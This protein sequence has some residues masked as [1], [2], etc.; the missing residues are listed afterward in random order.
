MKNPYY[1]VEN[2]VDRGLKEKRE[3]EKIK[4][5][6]ETIKAI[7]EE[8]IKDGLTE[9]QIF[10]LRYYGLDDQEISKRDFNIANVTSIKYMRSN[11]SEDQLETNR[12]NELID[13]LSTIE[14]FD[15]EKISEFNDRFHSEIKDWY[16]YTRDFEKDPLIVKKMR[17]LQMLNRM[18]HE[19]EFLFKSIFSRKN[20]EIYEEYTENYI[21]KLEINIRRMFSKIKSESERATKQLVKEF[22]KEKVDE[23]KN[24]EIIKY[25]IEA[26]KWMFSEKSKYIQEVLH[27]LQNSDEEYNYGIDVNDGNALIFDVPG[28]GQFSV[29]MGI[30]G[31]EKIKRLRE[32]EGVKDY[33]GEYLGNVYLLSKAD[34]ELLKN[35]NYEKLSDLDKQRYRIATQKIKEKEGINID[36]LIENAKDKEKAIEIINILKES[37]IKPEEVVTK[38]L[39]D[40]GQPDAIRD[41]I[42]IIEDNDYGIGLD[43]LPKC[44]TL[45]SVSQNKAIDIMEILDKIEEL[46]IDPNII[47]EYPNF[48]TVSKSEKIKPI[49]EVLEQYKINLTNHNLA[50][51]FQG[52]PENIKRN[53]DLAIEN[54]LYDLAQNGANKLFTCSNKTLNMRMNLFKKK[55]IPLVNVR[56]GKRR[57][58]SK[59][60]KTEEDI[61]EMYGI[62]KKQI[63]DELSQIEGQNLIKDNKYYVEE[64]NEQT[65]LSD[66]QQEISNSIYEK[67]DSYQED[68][69]VIR[70]GNYFY[71]A[72]KVKEQIDE[73]IANSNIQDIEKENINEILK[74]A[75]FKN[76]NINQ[77]EV[78]E[79]SEQIEGLVKEDTTQEK[80]VN[81]SD[82]QVT[83]Q[84]KE[85][86]FTDN[87]NEE[88]KDDV[89]EEQ[90]E[91][92]EEYE[93]GKEQNEDNAEYEQIRKMTSD[94]VEGQ[95]N[96]ETMEQTIG[97][98][99]E[100]RKELKQQI[101]E[102]EDKINQSI[103]DNDEPDPEVIQ[104]IKNL[105]KIVE[106]QKEKRKEIKQMIKKYKENR[107]IMKNNL[108]QEK[109][110]RKTAIDDLEL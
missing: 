30:Y 83:E 97:Q 3:Q 70:I 56:K 93:Q 55:N 47:N 68:G 76:K 49:Y 90:N 61:M 53:I 35:V 99:K 45:L 39:L 4:M 16:D 2:G 78:D 22:G 86:G 81:E 27:D 107:K 8:P 9:E 1:I 91:T 37:G 94:I 31:T 15:R 88:T 103:L 104:D 23:W 89:Q 5:I 100:T 74:I 43:I 50:V 17:N 26:R 18:G 96:I 42:E 108:K 20:P 14:M 19:Y 105:Q 40:K 72:I 92:N 38:T 109:K 54:G 46:H 52:T 102:L 32:L 57:I 10:L 64:N 33:E 82:V 66:K 25:C 36:E 51:A 63:L 106:Q 62:E 12:F 28:Y 29:H 34:P 69:I 7:I 80:N 95:Q 6:E 67:L 85:E 59:L 21:K 58:N 13:L 48:L 98:L 110:E 71:S 101:Q 79:V 87:L 11:I 60:F 44:K 77:K 75:L 73:I 24:D 84:Q 41:V 65:I